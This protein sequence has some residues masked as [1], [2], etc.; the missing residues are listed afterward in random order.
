MSSDN[1]MWS[2]AE[3]T[4][5]PAGRPL[6]PEGWPD[7]SFGAPKPSVGYVS[8]LLAMTS[9]PVAWLW[10]NSLTSKRS[11]TEGLGD[12]GVGRHGRHRDRRLGRR[13]HGRG[14]GGER[15]RGRRPRPREAG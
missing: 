14:A 12:D 2:S 15:R 11:S 8:V 3:T 9:P 1:A 5:V 13:R 7:R 6:L 10:Q 4:R